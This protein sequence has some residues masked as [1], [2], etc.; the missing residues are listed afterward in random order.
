[1]YIWF[2]VMC[3][4]RICYKIIKCCILCHMCVLFGMV[5]EVRDS[6]FTLT[7]ELNSRWVG[8]K[9]AAPT[10]TFKNNNQ[11]VYQ[12]SARAVKAILISLLL[13]PSCGKKV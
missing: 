10:Q 2:Y 13:L 6:E 11:K 7:D 4:C 12:C 9:E 3:P 5:C 8:K 1:M